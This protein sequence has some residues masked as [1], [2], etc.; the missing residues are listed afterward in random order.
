MGSTI[1]EQVLDVAFTVSD[2]DTT[3]PNIAMQFKDVGGNDID[4]PVA[5][6][7]YLST[8]A[9]G[10]TLAVDSTDTSQIAIGTDGT[11]LYEPVTDIAAYCVSE[12]DGDL[13]L[14]ITVVDGKSVY[15]NVVMPNGEVSTCATALYYSS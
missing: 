13:D 8:D 5:V 3:T 10:Q 6:V 1:S 15:F 14:E 9:Y 11:I 7:C 12:T 2:N 4:H